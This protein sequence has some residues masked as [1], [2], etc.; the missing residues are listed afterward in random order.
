MSSAK[1]DFDDAQAEV[2]RLTQELKSA[3]EALAA[4]HKVL[5]AVRTTLEMEKFPI[6]WKNVY[7]QR[8]DG[9]MSGLDNFQGAATLAGYPYFLWNDRVYWTRSGEYVGSTAKDIR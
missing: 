1:Q 7:H 6:I 5:E 2:N 8:L 4:A 9:L 3:K